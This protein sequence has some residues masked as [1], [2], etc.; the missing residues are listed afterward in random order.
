VREDILRDAEVRVVRL[1]GTRGLVAAADMV[2]VGA[3]AGAKL[4]CFSDCEG[5]I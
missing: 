5:V 1:A 2:D 4:P 3:S